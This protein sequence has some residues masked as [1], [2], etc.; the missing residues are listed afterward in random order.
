MRRMAVVA[1][2]SLTLLGGYS[3][4]KIDNAPLRAHFAD[5]FDIDTFSRGNL[6]AHTIASDG[7]A[8]A[9]DVIATYRALGYRFIALTDHNKLYGVKRA[10]AHSSPRFIVVP[11]EEVTMTGG[12]KQ[13]HVNALC[14]TVPI[15]GGAFDRP[16]DALQA[17]ASE[18]NAQRGVGLVNHPNFD[19]AL[20]RSDVIAVA[21]SIQLIEIASGHP[22]VHERG[23]GAKLSHEALWDAVLTAGFNV[24]GVAVDDE[25]HVRLSAEPPAFA[26]SGWVDLF[27]DLTTEEAICDAL[28][29]GRLIASTGPRIKRL[30]VTPE[31]Y[32]ITL[33][34]PADRV[35]FIGGGGRV[36]LESHELTGAIEYRIVGN[37]QYVR[38]RVDAG[39][40]HAWTPALAIFRGM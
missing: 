14:T 11:G 32:T 16:F 2:G 10:A 26:A 5:T 9:D 24:A 38:A 35:T 33:D 25:H 8:P 31:S 4:G 27:G 39:D 17:A 21:P 28:K 20:R 23:D 19:W 12:G 40:K 29:H 7:D 37:E 22:Y 18:V 6:H 3:R 30:R 34:Q 1:L 36:L 13:V 15:L